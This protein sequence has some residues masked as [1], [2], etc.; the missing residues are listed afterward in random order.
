M[1]LDIG[2]YILQIARRSRTTSRPETW[3]VVW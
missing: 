2:G 3:S 1:D